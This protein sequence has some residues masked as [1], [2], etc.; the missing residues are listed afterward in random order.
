M[1]EAQKEDKVIPAAL[2]SEFGVINKD[3]KAEKFIKCGHYLESLSISDM[4]LSPD[5]GDNRHKTTL[6]RHKMR[7]GAAPKVTYRFPKPCLMSISDLYYSSITDSMNVDNLYYD[8]TCSNNSSFLS[9]SSKYRDNYINR[10]RATR[11]KDVLFKVSSLT[12]INIATGDR[13]VWKTELLHVVDAEGKE[14]A[15][16]R[17]KLVFVNNVASDTVP[18]YDLSVAAGGMF[19]DQCVISF[20]ETS[21]CAYE[22]SR[23]TRS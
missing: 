14:Q 20:K 19:E 10:V 17:L 21:T 23:Q 7:S 18:F 5:N 6:S 4:S 2:F 3:F 11:H 8:L 13:C 15:D 16:Y 1:S 22:A 9:D 12:T